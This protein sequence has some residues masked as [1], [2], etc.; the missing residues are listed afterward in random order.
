MDVVVEEE[1]VCVAVVV[2]VVVDLE[3]V[4]D[5]LIDSSKFLGV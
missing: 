1:G 3:G 4:V 2:V 5:L